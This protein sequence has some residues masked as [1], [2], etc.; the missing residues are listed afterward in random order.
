[1]H[2]LPSLAGR[3]GFLAGDSANDYADQYTNSHADKHTDCHANGNAGSHTDPT[4]SASKR[5]SAAK[6]AVE[7]ARDQQH[8]YHDQPGLGCCQR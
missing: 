4:G 6:R 1:M 3:G 7:S 8:I 2:S 5:H